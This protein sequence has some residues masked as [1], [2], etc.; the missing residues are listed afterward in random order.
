MLALLTVIFA[1]IEATVETIKILFVKKE[2]TWVHVV[3]FGLGGFFAWF[4]DLNLFVYLDIVPAIGN[5]IVILIVNILLIGMLAV[6]YS[7]VFNDLLDFLGK[8]KK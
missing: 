8:L 1:L 3:V 6:R 5:V 4:F 7:G 2:G